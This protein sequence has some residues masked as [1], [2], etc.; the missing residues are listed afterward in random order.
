MCEG[1]CRG[2]PGQLACHS[3]LKLQDADEVRC[4][5]FSREGM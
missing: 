1:Q 4:C 2:L 3:Q 5:S